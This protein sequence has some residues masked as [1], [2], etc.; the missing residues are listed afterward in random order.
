MRLCRAA[1]SRTPRSSGTTWPS[2]GYASDIVL[3]YTDNSWLVVGLRC[4]MLV[5][6][7]LF[8]TLQAFEEALTDQRT[9]SSASAKPT[10]R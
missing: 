3:C 10:G 6:L 1:A 2:C 5:L 7:L 4:L 9:R 8:V